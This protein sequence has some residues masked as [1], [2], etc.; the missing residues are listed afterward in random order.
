LEIYTYSNG[1][2]TGQLNNATDFTVGETVHGNVSG[3]TATVAA[4]HN[5]LY[6]LHNCDAT[7]GFGTTGPSVSHKPKTGYFMVYDPDVLDEVRAG[8]TTDYTVDPTSVIDLMATY[9][10]PQSGYNDTQAY[11]TGFLQDPDD[12]T[13]F[14]TLGNMS[15]NGTPP[16]PAIIY[17]WHINDSPAPA[18][19]HAPFSLLGEL[20]MVCLLSLAGWARLTR[21]VS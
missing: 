13:Y 1:F 21:K 3:H 18:P 9:T 16:Q 15:A 14:Y 11:M 12:P 5:Q 10:Y 4:Y 20:G 6:C 7:N 19:A 17:K 2:S 8:S